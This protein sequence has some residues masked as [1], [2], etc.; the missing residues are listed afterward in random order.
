MDDFTSYMNRRSINPL[1]GYYPPQSWRWPANNQIGTMPAQLRAA[2]IFSEAYPSTFGTHQPT[3]RDRF[4]HAGG[5]DDPTQA[6]LPLA[7]SHDPG[8]PV[9]EAP[10][11]PAILIPLRQ[12]NAAPVIPPPVDPDQNYPKPP[13]VPGQNGKRDA[14]LQSLAIAGLNMMKAGGQ[15]YD[16]PVGTGAIIGES[17]LQGINA[18]EGIRKAQRDTALENRKMANEDYKLSLERGKAINDTKFNQGRLANDAKFNQGRLAV[19]NRQADTADKRAATDERRAGVMER[20]YNASDVAE[21]NKVKIMAQEANRR[22]E[23]YSVQAAAKRMELDAARP[24]ADL[25]KQYFAAGTDD[26]K[27]SEI[28]QQMNDLR[29]K[30]DDTVQFIKVDNGYD[31][32]GIKLPES[33]YFTDKSNGTAVEVKSS[34]QQKQSSPV[35]LAEAIRRSRKDPANAKYTD[36]QIADKLKTEYQFQE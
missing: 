21:S 1:G 11:A 32:N 28:V 6:P 4:L 5:W 14:I 29:G 26:I 34:Q 17:G 10:L 36:Q 18:Y 19:E 23:L 22:G 13:T 12:A 2:R 7:I 8:A 16:R 3:N 30:K 24:L 20:H 25:T 9:A 35:P 27:R 31:E 15:T 33:L